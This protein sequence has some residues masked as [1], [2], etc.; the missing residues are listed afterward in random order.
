MC[1]ELLL[2]MTLCVCVCVCV[3]YQMAIASW[4]S[5]VASEMGQRSHQCLHAQQYRPSACDTATPHHTHTL[6]HA[7]H[8]CART[9]AFSFTTVPIVSPHFPPP[10][11]NVFSQRNVAPINANHTTSRACCITHCM[12]RYRDVARDRIRCGCTRSLRVR[13]LSKYADVLMGGWMG[14]CACSRAYTLSPQSP[15]YVC[16]GALSSNYADLHS[17]LMDGPVCVIRYGGQ[18]ILGDRNVMV[19]LKRA[20]RALSLWDKASADPPAPDDTMALASITHASFML[21]ALLTR[22]CVQ[23]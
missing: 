20:W 11:Q 19:T 22:A 18:V 16:A 6:A 5:N 15:V 8:V 4:T 17:V 13:I 9:H 1:V 3:W 2:M 7:S 14:W 23:R 10:P 21:T 12:H